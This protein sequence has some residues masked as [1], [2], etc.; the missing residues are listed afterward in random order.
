MVFK[1]GGRKAPPIP[2]TH[3]TFVAPV[4]RGQ[5]TCGPEP[6]WIRRPCRVSITVSSPYVVTQLTD[7]WIVKC[8]RVNKRQ[9]FMFWLGFIN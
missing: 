8:D 6:F 7:L 3:T 4:A 5:S 2:D 1:G 9:N